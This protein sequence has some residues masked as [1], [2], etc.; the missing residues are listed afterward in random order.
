MEKK[1]S[2]WPLSCLQSKLLFSFITILLLLLY[3][4]IIEGKGVLHL[5]PGEGCAVSDQERLQSL[6]LE[7]SMALKPQVQC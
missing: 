1:K 3:S 5:G 2:S 6:S 7:L 4:F